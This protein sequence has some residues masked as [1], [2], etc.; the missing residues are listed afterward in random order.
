MLAGAAAPA[1]D[2]VAL[3]Y[4]VK[5]NYLYKFAPFVRW[6]AGAFEDASSPL[7]ICIAG[8]DPFGTTLDKAVVGQQVGGRS[9]VVRRIGTA[10]RPRCHILFIGRSAEALATEIAPGEPILTVGDRRRAPAMIQFAVV[11]GRVRFAV[12]VG[13]AQRGN[14][15][16]S[17][18]LL[19]LAMEVDR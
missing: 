8:S 19:G 9:I 13:A 15:A 1:A 6:P 16:L 18:K 2:P 17:S 5:A 10:P 3:E 11:G 12:D 14:I 4:A 7:R